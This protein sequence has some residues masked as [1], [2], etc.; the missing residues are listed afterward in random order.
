MIL[1]HWI[2]KLNCKETTQLSCMVSPPSQHLVVSMKKLTIHI[3]EVL[4]WKLV[5]FAGVGEGKPATEDIEQGSDDLQK[6]VL[7]YSIVVVSCN[8]LSLLRVCK[9]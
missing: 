4:L 3:E 7:I 5:Q 1:W 8:R 6:Y 9:L 2:A